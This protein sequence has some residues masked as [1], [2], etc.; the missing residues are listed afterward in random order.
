[1]SLLVDSLITSD[2]VCSVANAVCATVGGADGTAGGA[3]FRVY[4]MAANIDLNNN[5]VYEVR[6]MLMTQQG[7]MYRTREGSHHESSDTL[8]EEV[9]CG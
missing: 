4:S 1:M 3:L 6:R 7:Q 5:S 9:Q 8:A 2:G